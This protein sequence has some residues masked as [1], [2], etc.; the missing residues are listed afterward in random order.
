MISR[1]LPE[2]KAQA[3]ER[4]ASGRDT[5]C[6]FDEAS[7]RKEVAIA[8]LREL[9]LKQKSGA[10]VPVEDLENVWPAPSASGLI[11]CAKSSVC[12]N[13]SGFAAMLRAKMELR[14]SRSS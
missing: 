1:Q 8:G 10:L 11:E 6:S 7:R 9:E 4:A 12:F 2:T 13:V 3:A 14:A 5:N